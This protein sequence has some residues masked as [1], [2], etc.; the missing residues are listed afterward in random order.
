MLVFQTPDFIAD[1]KVPDA[2]VSARSA[3]SS[4]LAN[5]TSLFLAFAGRLAVMDGELVL[6]GVCFGSGGSKGVV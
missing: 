4:A 3:S 2:E 1:V 6:A 5:I